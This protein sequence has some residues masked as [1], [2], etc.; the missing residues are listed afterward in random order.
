M[1]GLFKLRRLI[2][3]IYLIKI[4]KKSKDEIRLFDKKVTNFQNYQ[5]KNYQYGTIN[6]LIPPFLTLLI[7][8]CLFV[9]MRSLAFLTLEFVGIVLRLFQQIG[10]FNRNIGNV[11][12]SHAHLEK[13]YMVEK[14]K[15]LINSE[16]FVLDEN[17]NNN[18]ITIEN[19]TFKYLGSESNIFENLDL[20][21]KKNKHTI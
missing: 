13:L 11:I 3:N 7:L 17:L 10:E 2:D 5:F 16:N 4:L 21:I 1:L 8:S 12:N 6:A 9:F 18:A 20:E 19:V 14:N 15:L